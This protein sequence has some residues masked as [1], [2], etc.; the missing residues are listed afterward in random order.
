MKSIIITLLVFSVISGGCSSMSSLNS[1]DKEN[2]AGTG[3]A[4]G[5][6]AL[7]AVP[8]IF[9]VKHVKKQQI[10]TENELNSWIGKQQKD[11]LSGYGAPTR[12]STDGSNGQ[13]LVYEK[14]SQFTHT[15]NGYPY[16]ETLKSSTQFFINSE[17]IIYKYLKTNS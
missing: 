6:G 8:V 1:S 2:L 14:V 3:I 17:N 4:L 5:V 10:K 9:L 13:I 15:K 7:I 12:T 16:V 11:L